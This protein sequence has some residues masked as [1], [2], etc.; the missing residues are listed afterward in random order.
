[1][2]VCT[3]MQYSGS[4]FVIPALEM[5]SYLLVVLSLLSSCIK[6]YKKSR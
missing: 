2:Y 4:F 3:F 5:L 6:M 1:M